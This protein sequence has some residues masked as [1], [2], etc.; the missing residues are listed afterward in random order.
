MKVMVRQDKRPILKDG[1]KLCC[2]WNCLVG[3]GCT[4]KKNNSPYYQFREKRPFIETFY[5][6]GTHATE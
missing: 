6:F 4:C 1:G 3:P 2:I 5:H